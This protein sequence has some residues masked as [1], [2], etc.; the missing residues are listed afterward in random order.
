[1][2]PPL[3]LGV[4]AV[5]PE[6]FQGLANQVQAI[7]G[8]LQTIIPHISQLAQQPSPQPQ[9]APLAPIGVTPLTK[10]RPLATQPTDNLP[11]LSLELDR[12]PSGDVFRRA[13]STPS[14]LARSPPDPDTFSSDSTDSPR[15]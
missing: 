12:A 1:M 13:T 4:S 10:G 15:A 8:M 14:S 6:A 3:N 2:P 11:Q 5:T 7:A 9:V